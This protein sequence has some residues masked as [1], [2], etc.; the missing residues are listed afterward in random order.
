MGGGVRDKLPFVRW[1]A[2]FFNLIWSFAVFPAGK[3][4]AL[5]PKRNSLAS[6]SLRPVPA[7][8]GSVSS[9]RFTFPKFH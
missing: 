7:G 3:M 2:Q 1:G 5:R 8:N 9:L 6:D 4:G